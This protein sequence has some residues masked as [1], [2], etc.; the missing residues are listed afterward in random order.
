MKWYGLSHFWRQGH[1]LYYYSFIHIHVFQTCML[2][3][4][5]K[6][7]FKITYRHSTPFLRDPI[8]S[9]NICL[10]RV[11]RLDDHIANLIY[12]KFC[13]GLRL[14]KPLLARYLH[15]YM[16]CYQIINCMWCPCS[17]NEQSCQ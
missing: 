17:N 11:Q 14:I 3:V 5:P 10:A 6:H 9:L 16:D 8:D 15:G 12:F 1:Y 13:T 7:H 2:S 4:L